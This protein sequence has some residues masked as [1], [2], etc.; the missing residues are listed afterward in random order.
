MGDGGSVPKARRT[1][2]QQA[3]AG[4]GASCHQ[5]LSAEQIASR[6]A[7]AQLRV[8]WCWGPSILGPG[9]SPSV[10][11]PSGTTHHKCPELL[12]QTQRDPSDAHC[13]DVT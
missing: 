8:G 9:S 11:V 6:A 10:E 4:A 12:S 7:S 1:L 2:G 5:D 3:G 13:G